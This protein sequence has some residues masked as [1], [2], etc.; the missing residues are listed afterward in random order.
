MD[1]VAQILSETPGRTEQ[2]EYEISDLQSAIQSDISKRK[3]VT[4]YPGNYANVIGGG[5]I[6]IPE[7]VSVTILPGCIIEYT[8]DFR[9]TKFETG[10][11]GSY[12]D[13]PIEG[14]GFEH[15]LATNPNVPNVTATRYAKPK[16]VGHV[17]NITDLNLASEWSFK[18]EFERS[19][20]SL[21]NSEDDEVFEVPF[22]NVVEVRTGDWVQIETGEIETIDKG[23]FLKID[24]EDRNG[25]DD[26]ENDSPL[27]AE[28]GNDISSQ[29]VIKSLEI[30]H[31]H[32]VGGE[33]N[34]VVVSL[35]ST[36]STLKISTENNPQN[37][38]FV[39]IT[40]NTDGTT[41][42]PTSEGEVVDSVITD[43][44]GHVIDVVPTETVEQL[45][46]GT[47]IDIS[48]VDSGRFEINHDII[49]ELGPYEDTP[50]TQVVGSIEEHRPPGGPT[51]HIIETS[52]IDIVGNDSINTVVNSN[53]NIELQVN[54]TEQLFE[55]IHS[56][57]I[58]P[59]SD[60]TDESTF[61]NE[62][63]FD[64]FGHVNG[65]GTQ[66]VVE[67]I[68]TDADITASQ[69]TGDVTIGIGSLSQFTTNDLDEG[70]KNLYYK[71]SRVDTEV[72]RF[73]DAGTN[74]NFDLPTQS[75]NT[76]TINSVQKSSDQV[77]DDVFP[78]VLNGTQ[79][80]INVTYDTAN[81]NVNYVVDSDLSNYDNSN[82]NFST[83]TSSDF[84]TDFSNKTTDDLSEGSINEYYTGAKV[85]EDVFSAVSGGNTDITV[86][87]SGDSINLV[88]E[89]S[90]SVQ[91]D[92]SQVVERA[93][94]IN[95]STGFSV[96]SPSG[97][98]NY[99]NVN[100][101]TNS[102]SIT[103]TTAETF[104]ID[105]DGDNPIGLRNNT[106]GRLELVSDDG[107]SFRDLKVRNLVVSGTTTTINTEQIVVEDND[108]LLN[109]NI[110]DVDSPT[111]DGGI[112]LKRGSESNAVI[113]WNESEDYWEAGTENSK[114]RILTSNDASNFQNNF[115][116][117]SGDTMTGDL[118]IA[119]GNNL[120]FDSTNKNGALSNTTGYKIEFE[121][122]GL[123][124]NGPNPRLSIGD[125]DGRNGLDLVNNQI[126]RVDSI[127]FGGTSVNSITTSIGD[128]GDDS[129]LVTEA[130][131]RSVIGNVSSGVTS[132]S[133]GTDISMSGSDP[134]SGDV[135][136]NH[137]NTGAASSTGNS[138]GTVLQT[139][140][141]D[142][143]GHVSSVSTTDLNS[144]FVEESG[145]TMS[146]DLSFSGGT[147]DSNGSTVA[148]NIT[149]DT[150]QPSSSDGDD[151]D[152]WVV[153]N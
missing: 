37:R 18:Q 121:S 130:A 137:G 25:D 144:Q 119:D 110:S 93:N 117:E 72:E 83:Y 136:V 123:E 128:P 141:T 49:P 67:S 57:N 6:A 71:D 145:D 118:T 59:P 60:E 80:L 126:T 33:S 148:R 152:I 62:L 64:D 34:E 15:P 131:V 114:A 75:D 143:N 134:A 125:Q 8:D 29:E 149:I 100:F 138:G 53:G 129:T 85:L 81:N 112:D 7:N 120:V 109:S 70:D 42:G 31:G 73:L 78:A 90:V 46:E 38:G 106:S 92:E 45:K 44:Q 68:D 87:K 107:N 105:T 17:E 84:D 88:S 99:I 54:F 150:S 22:E 11:G 48:E 14:D 95:F 66:Q 82:S 3:H 96:S 10:E 142:D 94:T 122:E 135:T 65:I 50:N 132:V 51:G 55:N 146:G 61:I 27:E 97:K 89:S 39:K 98:D 77:Q 30:D 124:V 127:D 56:G 4:L 139:I 12:R 133:G 40:H 115:V 108:I 43:K 103:G 86:N 32:I 147:A 113:N 91:E 23:P 111:E 21:R 16:F 36:D 69:S 26:S 1:I 9:L 5:E 28:I 151:G 140:N 52:A 63:E 74:I 76:L 58:S 35:E 153:C 104:T 102:T 19:L 47:L 20:W 13:A 24:H 79:T 2:E 101:D 116:S 41:V